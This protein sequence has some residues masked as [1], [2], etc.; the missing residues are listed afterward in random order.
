M[1]GEFIAMKIL[2]F[3]PTPRPINAIIAKG[4]LVVTSAHRDCVI[5]ELIFPNV[6]FNIVPAPK[7]KGKRTTR[8]E[9][10][11]ACTMNVGINAPY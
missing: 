9:R 6:P 11:G 8:S 10:G 1:I 2:N 3:F 7:G 5:D 4:G